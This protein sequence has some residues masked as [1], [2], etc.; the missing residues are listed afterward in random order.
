MPKKT[1]IALA[2]TLGMACGVTQGQ[3]IVECHRDHLHPVP[4]AD[5][6]FVTVCSVSVDSGL[7]LVSG[8]IN[9]WGT[10]TFGNV[11]L[12]GGT[13]VDVRTLPFD[14]TEGANTIVFGAGHP[15]TQVKPVP[16]GSGLLRVGADPHIY[17]LVGG[18]MPGQAPPVTS[19]WGSLKAECINGPCRDR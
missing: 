15:R 13:S 2:I 19:A 6:R 8:N 7:W 18:I 12:W 14:G 1:I 9:V 17:L 3:Q 16:F 5:G 10:G 11:F 4:V